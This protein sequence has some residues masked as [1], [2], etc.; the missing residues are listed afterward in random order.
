[1]VHQCNVSLD[2]CLTQVRE[3]NLYRE[4]DRTPF[5]QLLENLTIGR[6]WQEVMKQ[7]RFENRRGEIEKF[8]R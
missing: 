5:N 3:L 6:C 2:K 1:M 8:N 7:S 4:G